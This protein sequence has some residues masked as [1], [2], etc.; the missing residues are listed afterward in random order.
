MSKLAAVTS[1]TGS[2]S[3]AIARAFQDRGYAVRGLS[4]KQA[5]ARGVECVAV[6]PNSAEDMARALSGVDVAVF[7]SP[8][9]YRDGVRERLAEAFVGGAAKAG[10]RRVLFNPAAAVIENHDRPVSVSLR[11]VR[12]IVLGGGV[13]AA[14]IQPT[15]YMDNLAEPWAAPSIVNEGVLAYPMPEDAPVSWISHASLGAFAAAAAEADLSGGRIF[16]VGGPEALTGPQVAAILSRHVGREVRYMTL[17]LGVFGAALNQAYGPPVGDHIADLYRLMATDKRIMERD[18]GA[19][20]RLGVK[21]ETFDAWAA[22]QTW[23][24]A[25]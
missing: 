12:E 15:V 21:P 9:D 11:A 6:D 1:I 25:S 4:R 16:D 24:S 14:A 19:Y 8:I 23:P 10:V 22:R 2:Q 17:D 5:E 20:A 13:E 18:A 3:R 7:T